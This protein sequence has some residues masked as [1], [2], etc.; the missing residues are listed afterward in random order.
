MS[1]T[2]LYFGINNFINIG[3]GTI[4]G[5]LKLIYILLKRNIILEIIITCTIAH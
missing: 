2:Y 5:L 4:T 1:I 3:T